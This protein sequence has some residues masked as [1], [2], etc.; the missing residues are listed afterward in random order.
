MNI[1]RFILSVQCFRS[2]RSS[3]RSVLLKS[4][5]L[6]VVHGRIRATP[7]RIHIRTHLFFFLVIN[8]YFV[9]TFRST[10][11]TGQWLWKA[12]VRCTFGLIVLSARLPFLMICVLDVSRSEIFAW[13]TPNFQRGTV[14]HFAMIET[15]SD[16]SISSNNLQ[17]FSGRFARGKQIPALANMVTIT[18]LQS[19]KILVGRV[20]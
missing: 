1:L 4:V 9:R 15:N 13:E 12:L 5:L 11:L 16:A 10:F 3:S 20:S 14:L 8:I 7:V 18:C 2:Y 17:I 6:R 19:F